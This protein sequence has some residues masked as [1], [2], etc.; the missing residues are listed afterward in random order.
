VKCVILGGGGFIGSAVV[1]RLLHDGH[2]VRVFERPGVHPYRQ[3]GPKERLEWMSGDLLSVHDVEGALAGMDVVVHAAAT[4]LPK[5]SNDDPVYDVRSNLV[6]SIQMLEA[7]VKLGVRRMIFLSSGGTVYGS[8][9]YLPVDERHPTEPLVSMGINKLAVEKYVLMYRRLH[10]I[11]PVI[12]RVS[13]AFGPR[14]R[15]DAPQGAVAVFMHRTLKGLPIEIW[16]DG[17]AI[18]DFIFVEDLADAVTRATGY[19]GRESV[20]NV[21][22]GVGT[23]L[24]NLVGTIEEV[25]SMRIERRYLPPRAFDVNENVLD[26][27]LVTQEMGWRPKV[28]LR[29][30]LIR[31][32]E[33]MKTSL[34]SSS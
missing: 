20:F 32:A 31:T 25:L 34:A 1:D 9:S 2:A 30:G 33:W 10:D 28:T 6:A 22:S 17:G 13:N 12:L 21:G 23:S 8:P 24:R 11:A 5:T 15:V 29:E 27:R 26:N 19:T 14:Q 3:F 7:M 18:R 16:G 4:T